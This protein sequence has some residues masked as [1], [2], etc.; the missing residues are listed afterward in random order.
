MRSGSLR[1]KIVFQQLTVQSDTY[2]KSAETWTDQVSTF[3]AI[4]PIRGNEK[5]ENLRLENEVTHKIRIRYHRGLHPKMRIRYFKD[6][7]NRYYNIQSIINPDERNI[8]LEIMA[9]EQI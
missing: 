6:N 8:Y 4:W 9:I 5:L 1:H 3:A 7:A 2:S